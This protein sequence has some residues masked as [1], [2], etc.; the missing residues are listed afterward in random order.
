MSTETHLYCFS[1][2]SYLNAA[3]KFFIKSDKNI[4]SAVVTPNVTNVTHNEHKAV[5]SK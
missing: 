1:V 3:I 5:D 4:F 2:L